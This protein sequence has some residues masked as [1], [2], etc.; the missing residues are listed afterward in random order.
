MASSQSQIRVQKSRDGRY[1]QLVLVI[2]KKGLEKKQIYYSI[3]YSMLKNYVLGQTNQLFL[4]APPMFDKDSVKYK[5][6][7]KIKSIK[8]EGEKI[9]PNL[10]PV[11][12]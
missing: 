3:P 11:A 10:D 1:F 5:H 9:V 6:W 2:T 8:A 12:R 4:N 7:K